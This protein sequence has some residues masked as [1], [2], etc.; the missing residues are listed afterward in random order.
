MLNLFAAIVGIGLSLL[1]IAS[2]GSGGVKLPD[3]VA[4]YLVGGGALKLVISPVP[5]LTGVGLVLVVSFLATLYPIRVAVN[6][7]PLKAMSGN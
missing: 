3:I 5:F 1:L 4:Q 2:F 7:S 6:V